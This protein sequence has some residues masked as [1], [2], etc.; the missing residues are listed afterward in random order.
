MNYKRIFTGLLSLAALLTVFW[1][2]EE[3]DY[4]RTFEGPYHVRFTDSTLAFRESYSKPITIRVH[5]AGPQLTEP[6]S[7]SYAIGGTAREGKD[8]VIEGTRG[9]V[10]IPAR[11]SF[12][13]ITLRMVNNANNI[14]ESQ[15][16]VFTMTAVK[17]SNLQLGFGTR[18]PIGR[19]L[20]FTIQDDCLLSGQYTGTRRAGSTT[21]S[22]P[23][24]DIT[25][26]DC[27]TY[28]LTNWNI[29]FFS[30][31]A[32]KASLTFTDVGDNSLVI[33]PQRNDQ[34]EAP[35]DTI[36]GTGSW[37]PRDR[38]ITLNLRIKVQNTVTQRDT[39]I[40]Q[41]LTYIPQ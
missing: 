8:Y 7:I 33:A 6:I 20:T 38:R 18:N 21:V 14:L 36:S 12:G 13:T 15:N 30:F 31:N 29:G 41:T 22:V 23:D 16:I 39:T 40:T 27:K 37:N 28:T 5:N 11:Q 19:Q 17:P 24:I 10:I 9:V 35:R 26:L 2:C 34:L 25:S 4:D 1:A 3:T 32:T